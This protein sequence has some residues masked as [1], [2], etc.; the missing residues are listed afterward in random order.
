MN[1]RVD[2]FPSVRHARPDHEFNT[3]QRMGWSG[4]GNDELLDS[5]ERAGFVLFIVADKTFA[6]SKTSPLGASPFSNS[7]PTIVP[8]SKNISGKSRRPLLE[9]RRANT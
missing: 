8:P 9:S 1:L 6:A 5:A 3:S 2:P 7:G 4:L